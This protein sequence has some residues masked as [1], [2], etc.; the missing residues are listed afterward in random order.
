MRFKIDTT[1]VALTHF[2]NC[3]LSPKERDMCYSYEILNTWL[4]HEC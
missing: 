1:C 4:T 3:K 2:D